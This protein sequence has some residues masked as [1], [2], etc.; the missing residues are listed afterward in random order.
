MLIIIISLLLDEVHD[1]VDAKGLV[2]YKFHA[3][4]EGMV[5]L[6][7][8]SLLKMQVLDGIMLYNDIFSN[9]FHCI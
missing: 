5:H 2:K 1:E 4:N 7:Q 8:N 6:V 3:Y 9:T